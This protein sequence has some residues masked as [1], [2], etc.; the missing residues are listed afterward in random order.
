MAKGTTTTTGTARILLPRRRDERKETEGKCLLPLL[1]SGEHGIDVESVAFLRPPDT[2]SVDDL[3]RPPGVQQGR[4]HSSV[5]FS[6]CRGPARPRRTCFV[7][8]GVEERSDE[9]FAEL[10]RRYRRRWR[11]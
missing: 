3:G 10:L 1:S 4:L 8:E 6:D 5:P 2:L 7:D 9:R 11:G